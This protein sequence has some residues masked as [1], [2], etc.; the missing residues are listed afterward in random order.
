MSTIGGQVWMLTCLM[1]VLGLG[2]KDAGTEKYRSA[3][4][5]YEALV[6]K[7][8]NPRSAEFDA[9]QSELRAVPE[10]SDAYADAQALLRS[11]ERATSRAPAP[12]AMGARPGADAGTL[13]GICA[14]LAER[15]GRADAGE[16]PRYLQAL[17][18]CRRQLEEDKASHEG[19]GH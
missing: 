10:G 3:R 12:L 14:E 18:D 17:R 7:G 4:A 15:L 2:C 9:I 1:G 16:R 8:T 6:E 5:R 11:L 13:E 19:H